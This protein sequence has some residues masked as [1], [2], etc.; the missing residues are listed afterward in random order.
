MERPSSNIPI[1]TLR[2]TEVER[3][4]NETASPNAKALGDQF[5]NETLPLAR[6]V[7]AI[8]VAAHQDRDLI[9]P[10]LEQYAHQTDYSEPFTVCLLLNIPVDNNQD[11]LRQAIQYTQQASKNFPELDVRF[12]TATYEKPTIGAIRKDLWDAIAYRSLEDGAYRQPG[13]D[14]SILNQDIDVIRMNQHYISR[15]QRYLHATDS[16]GD[17]QSV[18]TKAASTAVRHDLPGEPYRNTTGGIAWSESMRLLMQPTSVSGGVE[19]GLVVPLTRYADA[20][21]FRL[22]SKIGE[23]SRFYSND[24]ASTMP[25]FIPGT[26][27]ITSPRRFLDRFPRFGYDNLWTD[28]SFSATDQCRDQSYQP[29]DATKKQRDEHIVNSMPDIGASL[30]DV[31]ALTTLRNPQNAEHVISLYPEYKDRV[32]RLHHLGSFVLER[33]VGSK[34]LSDLFTWQNQYYSEDTLLQSFVSNKFF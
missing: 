32:T 13:H 7:A 26:G 30:R 18:M 25:Q 9:Y 1:E 2:H 31:A 3:Y 14:I 23:T 4:L 22:A 20:G 19:A 33:L 21:G 10:T 29:V 15:V 6:V 34:S 17:K 24:R 28:D 11:D 27:L 8:P 12:A 16:P 5:K